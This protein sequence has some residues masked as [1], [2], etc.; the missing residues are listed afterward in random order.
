MS[1]LSMS[2]PLPRVLDGLELEEVPD[3]HEAR[4]HELPLG[5]AADGGERDHADLVDHEEVVPAPCRSRKRWK[6][7]WSVRPSSRSRAAA[8]VGREHHDGVLGPAAGA[9]WG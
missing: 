2:A 8:C 7:R 4:A 9:T 3:Q 1:A 5:E 6:A